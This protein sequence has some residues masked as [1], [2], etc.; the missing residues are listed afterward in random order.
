MSNTAKFLVLYLIP[1]VS[2]ASTF[3]VYLL[4]YGNSLGKTYINFGLIFV[5]LGFIASCFITVKLVYQFSSEVI[6]YSGIFFS[7]LAWLIE[8]VVFGLYFVVFYGFLNP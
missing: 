6:I 4:A 7:I 3:G 5:T 8:L 1:I 2:L